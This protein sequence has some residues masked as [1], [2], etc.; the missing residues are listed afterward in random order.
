MAFELLTKNIE[1][2][3]NWRVVGNSCSVYKDGKQV[4]THASGYSDKENGI[5]M[6]G[7]ETHY[8][9]SVSKVITCALAMTLFEDGLLRLDAPIADVLPEW[10]SPL[11]RTR[12]ANGNETLVPADRPI[13]VRD[14]FTMSAGLTYDRF[15]PSMLAAREATGGRLPTR[16]FSR[17]LAQE[18]LA[19]Q[20]GSEWCYSL[21]HDLLAA[22]CEE[23][24][25]MRFGELAER[26]FFAPIGLTKTSYGVKKGKNDDVAP[27]YKFEPDTESAHLN[28]TQKNTYILGNEYD[29]GGAGIVSCRD[30]VAKLM[31]T[32]A[33]GG[34]SAEGVRIIGENTL[35]L[36]RENA[37]AAIRGSWK[38][39][40]YK[41]YNYGLGVY[42]LDDPI[43]L[44]IPNAPKKLF[45]WCG[46]AGYH[47]I[48]DMENKLSLV[49]AE[50][51]HNSQEHTF[52]KLMREGLYADENKGLLF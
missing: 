31:D 7:S 21:C 10:R 2:M 20:P 18:P 24:V 30:D 1:Y 14:L 22:Y 6:T 23:L 12:D 43:A 45:G 27:L 50:H 26:R 32:F 48:I 28:E 37:I 49:Y 36:M 34:I 8:I 4:Y 25:G 47:V 40:Q 41:H 13:T 29:S 33:R 5:K 19:F 3:T 15:T 11:V 38:W 17:A 46:A 52:L 16:E 51:M 42:T 35:K 9:Y 44:G 39:E